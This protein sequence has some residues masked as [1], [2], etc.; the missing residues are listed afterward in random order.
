MIASLKAREGDT[1]AAMKIAKGLQARHPDRA[2]PYALEAE[3]LAA[4]E[5]Y[6]RAATVY[7]K[8][9]TLGGEDRRLA[10]GAYRVRNAG[11]LDAP[12]KPLLDYLEE[13]PLDADVR[14]IVAQHYQ[15][16]GNSDRAI[17]EYRKVLEQ[18]PDHFVALNNLAWEYFVTGD[19]RAEETARRAFE[20]SPENGAVADTLG[21]IQVKKGDLEQGIPMLREAVELTGGDPEVRYHLAAGLA[22]AGEA[23]QARQIL[24]ETLSEGAE[25]ASRAEA[26]RLLDSL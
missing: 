18:S 14:V 26:E 20:Q 7:E 16:L 12:E 2:V 24:Q 6:E 8:A 17:A 9:L 4:D 25:F 15:T 22:A 19:P 5:Q 3:L 21:W 1:E 13:R 10:V 11:G 23:D